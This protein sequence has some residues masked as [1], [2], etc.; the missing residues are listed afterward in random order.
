MNTITPG[1]LLQDALRRASYQ[2]KHRANAGPYEDVF[3]PRSVWLQMWQEM[4]SQGGLAGEPDFQQPIM[5]KTALFTLRIHA[6]QEMT[7]PRMVQ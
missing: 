6:Q 5:V 2:R 1:Q 4:Q 3:W 7:A